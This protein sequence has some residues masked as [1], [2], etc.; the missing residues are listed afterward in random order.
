MSPEIERD[1]RSHVVDVPD[2]I[3]NVVI[4]VVLEL[5]ANV[6]WPNLEAVFL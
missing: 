3:I 2:Y 6:S 4:V 1:I 5:R